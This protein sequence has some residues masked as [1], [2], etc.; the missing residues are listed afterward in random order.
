MDDLTPDQRRAV[1]KVRTLTRTIESRTEYLHGLYDDRVDAYAVA[2]KLGVPMRV[3]AEASGGISTNA[4]AK[5][6]DK[7][8]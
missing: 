6:M 5:A 4:V 8:G 3:L 7:R 1:T 2:R